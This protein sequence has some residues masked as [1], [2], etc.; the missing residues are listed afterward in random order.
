LYPDDYSE[1]L[2]LRPGIT[3]LAAVK[4]RFETDLLDGPDFEDRYRTEILPTKI[5]IERAY[6]ERRNLGLDLRILL[7]TSVAL[8]LGVRVTR[9]PV[10]EHWTFQRLSRRA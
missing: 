7:W 3:C 10:T 9:C 4:Y 5:A 6:A 8:L 2:R 1:I